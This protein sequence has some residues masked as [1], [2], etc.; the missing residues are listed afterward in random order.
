MVVLAPRVRYFLTG[1]DGEKFIE[2]G[3]RD[4]TQI[5]R[6]CRF[7]DKLISQKSQSRGRKNK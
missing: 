6:L 3:N 1:F 5:Y 2:I 7:T 4:I